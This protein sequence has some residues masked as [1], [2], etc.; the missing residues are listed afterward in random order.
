MKPGLC[1]QG[2]T[3]FV[4]VVVVA[5]F[6]FFFNASLGAHG[7]SQARGLIEATAAGLHCSYSNSGSEPC[8]RPTPQHTATPDPPPTERGQGSNLRPHG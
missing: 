8:L 5:I 6:F 4:V 3:I 7:S 1:S 2:C